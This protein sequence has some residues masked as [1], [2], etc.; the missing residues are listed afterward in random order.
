M[1]RA[2]EEWTDRATDVMAAAMLKILIVSSTL[3][4]LGLVGYISY[5]A[6]IGEPVSITLLI[7]GFCGDWYEVSTQRHH[8]T[9]MHP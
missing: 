8:I 2:M 6:I 5:R 1:G 3:M 9:E 7:N 4:M